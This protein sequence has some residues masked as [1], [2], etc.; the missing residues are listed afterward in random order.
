MRIGT[1]FNKIN[2]QKKIN[3]KLTDYFIK[4]KTKYPR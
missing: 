4:L 3:K 2:L 1:I